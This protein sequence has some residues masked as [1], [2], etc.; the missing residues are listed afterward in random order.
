MLGRGIPDRRGQ[1]F[2]VLPR[3]SV[4]NTPLARSRLRPRADGK[5]RKRAFQRGSTVRWRARGSCLASRSRQA[6]SGPH[7]LSPVAAGGGGRGLVAERETAP[8]EGTA[9]ARRAWRHAR[10]RQG[11]R[12]ELPVDGRRSGSR[13]LALFTEPGG[14]GLDRPGRRS[15]ARRCAGSGGDGMSEVQPSPG[16]TAKRT[17]GA[18]G[19]QADRNGS[20]A[21]KR[22]T[23]QRAKG[24]SLEASWLSHVARVLVFEMWVAEVGPKHLWVRFVRSQD[25]ATAQSS[26]VGAEAAFDEASR[27]KPGERVREAFILACTTLEGSVDPRWKSAEPGLDGRRSGS[28]QRSPLTRVT[29]ARS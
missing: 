4:R 20:S 28:N 24:L 11:L 22:G 15:V 9:A 8:R 6:A 19:G 10:R 17:C 12:V 18:N 3:A 5:R 7:K 1:C 16:R 21:V 26:R 2:R 23:H 27:S 29:H 13:K 14:S 25:R